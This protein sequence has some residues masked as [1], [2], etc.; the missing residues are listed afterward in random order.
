M[1]V[2]EGQAPNR[3]TTRIA[4]LR[5][6]KCIRVTVRRVLLHHPADEL[7]GVAALS[8]CRVEVFDI[9]TG[10]V[11]H[12]HGVIVG[13]LGIPVTGDDGLWLQGCDDVD[14]FEP[15]DSRRFRRPPKPHVNVVLHDIAGAHEVDLRDVNDCPEYSI[16]YPCGHHRKD[17]PFDF[18]FVGTERRR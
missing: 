15:G 13:S 2:A 7:I 4:T 12:T 18:D 1:C 16:P 14:R 11:E 6:Q 8:D 17:M 5:R 10:L 9:S 3:L